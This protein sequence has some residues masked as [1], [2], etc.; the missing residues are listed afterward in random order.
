MFQ[1]KQKPG[2]TIPAQLKPVK[3]ASIQDNR[4][5][6]GIQ[7]K[8]A[9]G[10]NIQRNAINTGTDTPIQ[11]AKWKYGKVG[12]WKLISGNNTNRALPFPQNPTEGDIFD[13]QTGAHTHASQ[14]Q[15]TNT[16][17]TKTTGMPLPNTNVVNRNGPNRREVHVQQTQKM[18]GGP[19][20]YYNSDHH[21]D[22]KFAVSV[23][24]SAKT[25]E[26]IIRIQSSADKKVFDNWATA[27]RDK[28]SKRFGLRVLSK[29]VSRAGFYMI[30]VNL[31]QV[32]AT[33]QP[34]HVVVPQNSDETFAGVR[35][36]KG[37]RSMTEWGTKD[38]VDV[39]HEVGHMLGNLDEYYTINDHVYTAPGENARSGVDVGEG[40]I[41]NDPKNNPLAKHYELIRKEAAAAIGVNEKR[42][43][44]E[45]AGHMAQTSNSSA[46][47][48][49]TNTMGGGISLDELSG[50][51]GSLK[52]T[53][54]QSL[55][56]VPIPQQTNTDF[57]SVLKK[58]PGIKPSVQPLEKTTGTEEEKPNPFGITL[59][60]T[61]K[62]TMDVPLEQSIISEEP[63]ITNTGPSL[64]PVKKTVHTIEPPVPKK[65]ET[66]PKERRKLPPP[67]NIISQAPEEQKQ[68]ETKQELT[69]EQVLVVQRKKLVSDGFNTL[70]QL[71][72]GKKE[73]SEREALIEAKD[74]LKASII[75]GWEQ[76][77]SDIFLNA[78][79]WQRIKSRMGALKE[80]I[81]ELEHS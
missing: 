37:T 10:M 78:D 69:G 31:V 48:T 7:K 21:V 61:R 45:E 50:Q 70:T 62:P 14:P 55:N 56:P 79:H 51:L 54:T 59:R 34:H 24:P 63:P 18:R 38:A 30:D 71:L 35:G 73:T 46:K 53:S 19:T 80:R 77:G 75:K 43:T 41:M 11:L 8:Q 36:M 81:N 64:K 27:T 39:P 76:L 58:P 6:A 25:C 66:A 52:K 1:Q 12:G 23:D 15:P 3:S 16:S 74:K 13:D 68:E 40:S 2:I 67:P 17:S 22:S 9:A 60:S 44:I 4:P 20:E 57:R 65:E 47:I 42:V 32:G 49:R 72:D 28:W 29:S 33:D 5:Q 26:V